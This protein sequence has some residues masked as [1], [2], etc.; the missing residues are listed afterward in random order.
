MYRMALDQITAA[1]KETRA[2]ITRNIACAFL[3]HGA[4]RGRRA[5]AARDVMEAKN[6]DRRM[7]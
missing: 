3:A 4:V 5:D 1:S 7:S 2:K 6:D